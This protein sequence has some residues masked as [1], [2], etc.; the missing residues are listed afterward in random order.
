MSY[1]YPGEYS[2]ENYTTSPYP[3]WDASEQPQLPEQMMQHHQQQPQAQ[4]HFPSE[5]EMS[6]GPQYMQHESISPQ[7]L[8]PSQ[9]L[10]Q[11]DHNPIH[12]RPVQQAHP[13]SGILHGRTPLGRSP[14]TSNRPHQRNQRAPY[15][16][17]PS[18]AGPSS[19]HVRFAPQ[20]PQSQAASPAAGPSYM[21][22]YGSPLSGTPQT[23]PETISQ[24]MFPPSMPVGTTTATPAA[25]RV[26]GKEQRPTKRYSIRS[27]IMLD[28]KNNVLVAVMELPGLR[29]GTDDLNVVLSTNIYNRIRQVNVEGR[30]N[31]IFPS[32]PMYPSS[33][34]SG[35]V[36]PSTSLSESTT[37]FQEG[38]PQ[39]TV[40]ERKYGEFSRSFIVPAETK[41][42]DIDVSFSD[43]LL[44]LRIML[45]KPAESDDRHEIIVQ[46]R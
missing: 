23:S 16:R 11:L 41:P 3:Q 44:V 8:V 17:S 46:R 40:R 19:Q 28:S 14:T 30:L 42:E 33:A 32:G 25:S 26:G 29:E 10:Q 5:A 45:G 27:D 18:A 22:S 7:Q 13:S 31:P 20:I 39:M 36:P 2:S 21:G 15:Q 1:S 43:G 12:L 37:A 35:A 9:R 38:S 6:Q 34:A 4:Q 24:G